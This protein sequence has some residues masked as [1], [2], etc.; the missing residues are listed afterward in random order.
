MVRHESSP[1]FAIAPDPRYHVQDVLVDG[2]SQG[3]ITSYTF[4]NV[5]AD[6]HTISATFG[7]NPLTI[8]SITPNYGTIA[9]NARGF[10]L[11]GTG[12]NAETTVQLTNFVLIDPTLPNPGS[13]DATVDTVGGTSITGRVDLTK[14]GIGQYDVVVTSPDGQSAILPKGFTVLDTNPPVTTAIP[15]GATYNASSE[16]HLAGER[17]GHDLLHYGWE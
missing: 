14:A 11:E 6:D 9:N 8:S 5:T 2:V 4:T 7:I 15:R 3:A 16:C 12:F 10:T 1:T 17:T 13:I